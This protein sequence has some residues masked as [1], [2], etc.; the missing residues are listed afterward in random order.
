MARHACKP[1]IKSLLTGR[2]A[3]RLIWALAKLGI[4]DNNL[5][6]EVSTRMMECDVLSQ[7]SAQDISMTIWGMAKARSAHLPLLEA[8][9]HEVVSKPGPLEEFEAQSV[10]NTIWGLATLGVRRD[11]LMIA[12]ADRTSVEGF[13]ETLKLATVCA[14]C[15]GLLWRNRRLSRASPRRLP[16]DISSASSLDRILENTPFF[17]WGIAREASH[18][19]LHSVLLTVGPTPTLLSGCFVG[20]IYVPGFP[21]FFAFVVKCQQIFRLSLHPQF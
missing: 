10:A 11:E 18:G 14:S 1:E 13:L 19:E 21:G 16:D 9:A 17:A 2:Q 4:Q 7:L 6:K 5:V 15:G 12:I 3:T 20:F 8:L